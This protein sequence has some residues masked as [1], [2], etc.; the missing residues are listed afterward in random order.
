MPP[1]PLGTG[2]R[3]E[4]RHPP[5]PLSSPRAALPSLSLDGPR[6]RPGL[7]PSHSPPSSRLSGLG[8]CCS[9]V[10]VSEQTTSLLLFFVCSIL[11]P[12]KYLGTLS[13]LSSLGLLSPTLASFRCGSLAAH[14]VCPSDL[15][16]IGFRSWASASSPAVRC[17]AQ[18]PRSDKAEYF[19]P[20]LLMSPATP[21]SAG[22]CYPVSHARPCQPI[23][24]LSFMILAPRPLGV[25]PRRFSHTHLS[26]TSQTSVRFV[27]GK[28]GLAPTGV[29]NPTLLSHSV[30]AYPPPPLLPPVPEPGLPV[31]RGSFSLIPPRVL[32]RPVNRASF[33]PFASS[34]PRKFTLV[35]P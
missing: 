9:Q 7:A 13:V 31:R 35:V 24:T 27:A 16:R 1:R 29:L 14:Q 22:G 5:P 34:H 4:T 19:K 20:S 28:S 33:V 18:A 10:P 30:T 25:G 3:R 32:R 11:A 17:F 23:P 26:S 6:S 21:S 12:A 2:T 8:L 15:L